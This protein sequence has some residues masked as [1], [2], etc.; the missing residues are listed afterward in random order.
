MIYEGRRGEIPLWN[1]ECTKMKHGIQ[2]I[3]RL[4]EGLFLEED[5]D[6][7]YIEHGSKARINGDKDGINSKFI[8][9]LYV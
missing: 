6:G 1:F 3:R 7:L 9:Q 2:T 4:W 8:V 5:I